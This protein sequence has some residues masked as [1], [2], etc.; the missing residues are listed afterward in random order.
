MLEITFSTPPPGT[1][2]PPLIAPV[3]P[4]AP[5]CEKCPLNAMPTTGADGVVVMANAS[6]AA[7][8]TPQLSVSSATVL[9]LAAVAF[10]AS[11]ALMISTMRRRRNLGSSEDIETCLNGQCG[12]HVEVE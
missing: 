8:D 9:M 4:P 7:T 6:P 11:A 2:A 12:D 1:T 5:Q 3:C 10:G